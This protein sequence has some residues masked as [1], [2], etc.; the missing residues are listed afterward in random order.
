MK[1]SRRMRGAGHVAR[2]GEKRNAYSLFVGKPLVKRLL[3][4]PRLRW[5]DTTRMDL[6]EM[7]GGDVD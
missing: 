6:G 4:R 2:M 7:G 1:K 3:R 5:V